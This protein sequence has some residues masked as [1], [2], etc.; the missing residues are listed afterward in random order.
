MA[1]QPV[2]AAFDGPA[3][4]VVIGAERGWPAAAAATVLAMAE[5][6]CLGGM[7]NFDSVAV[8]ST[9]VS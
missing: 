7:V 3:M 6:V 5:L 9:V 4:L 1:F 2:D 8:R